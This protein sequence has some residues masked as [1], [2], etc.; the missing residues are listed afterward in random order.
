MIVHIVYALV[1]A[2]ATG[3][4][5][6][7]GVMDAGTAKT[8][9]AWAAV[10]QG[11]MAIVLAGFASSKTGP[12]AKMATKY[13]KPGAAILLVIGLATW[14]H[15]AEAAT[16][17]K[18][19]QLHRPSGGDFPI[20]PPV[21]TVDPVNDLMQKIAAVK[22]KAIAD[23]QA[24][25][26]IAVGPDPAHPVD[27]LGHACYPAVIQF[28]NNVV[29]SSLPPVT[30][31]AVVF[32]QARILRMQLQAGLPTYLKLGCAPLAQDEATMLVK[33][34]GLIG[35]AINPAILIRGGLILGGG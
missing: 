1:V 32:E 34:G 5:S 9:V 16:P 25:D 30:G 33:L 19:Q 31:P 35:V 10:V 17:M 22:D 18:P 12:M 8:I 3:T 11:V 27:A 14:Q 29:P 2:V 24:A 4:L 26:G 28:L 20:R 15:R 7:T 13:L 21:P 6:L 23:L